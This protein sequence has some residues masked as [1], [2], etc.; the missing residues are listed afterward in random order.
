M[1]CAQSKQL[2]ENQSQY[3]LKAKELD[4]TYMLFQ[5]EK[6]K[7]KQKQ[8][9]HQKILEFTKKDMNMYKD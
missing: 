9:K 3:K 5:I 7:F 8:E 2:L 1:I 6:Q 4:E